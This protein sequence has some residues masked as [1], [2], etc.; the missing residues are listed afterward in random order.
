MQETLESIEKAQELGLN[1]KELRYVAEL[2]QSGYPGTPNKDFVGLLE[3]TFA[4][5]FGSQYAIS[6]VNGTATLHSALVAGGVGPGDEVIVPP[7]TMASTAL[8]VLYTQARPVFAD[9]DPETF[10]IDPRSIAE[11][12][13]PET[14][15]IIPVSLYGLAPDMDPIMAL[16]DKHNLLVV[17]DAAQCFLGSYR[18]RTVGS[19]GHVGSFSFQNSKHMTCGEGGIVITSDKAL[20]GKIRRFTSLGY[21]LVGAEPGASKIDKRQIVN[22]RFERHVDLGFNYRISEILAAVAL[23]Q[24]ENLDNAVA[25]RRAAAQAFDE[26]V[27][28]CSWLIPQKI[29]D[30]CHHAFWSYAVKIAPDRAEDLWQQFYDRFIEFGGEGFYGAWRLTYT[31]PIFRSGRYGVHEQGICPVAERIQPRL[32]QFKTNYWDTEEIARQAEALDKTIRHF[33]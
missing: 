15:A 14:K 7:L 28:R 17:E 3:E 24:L 2:F 32:M 27:S 31:E 16:A 19:I 13:T 9:I 11:K 30:D 4:R 10:T 29:P 21:S 8:A 1:G 23:A 26:V 22:P 5:K 6:H 12:I 33:K 18:G 25:L 20:A